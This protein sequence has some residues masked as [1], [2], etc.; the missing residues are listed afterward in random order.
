VPYGITQCYLLPGKDDIPAFTP[1]IY[2]WYLNLGTLERCKT[3]LTSWF[4]YIIKWYSI[5]YIHPPK[6][7]QPF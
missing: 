7:S 6:F 5:S 1:H 2:S 4:N 3:E